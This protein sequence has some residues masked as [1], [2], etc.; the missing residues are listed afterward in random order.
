M[1]F[2]VFILLLRKLISNRKRLLA[3]QEKEKERK[4]QAKKVERIEKLLLELSK[5]KTQSGPLNQSKDL[6]DAL[7]TAVKKQQTDTRYKQALDFLNKK[8][9]EKAEQLFQEIAEETG[10]K[11]KE[12]S[13]E[14]AR[15]YRQLGA[16]AGLADPKRAVKAYIKSLE[17]E[18]D[19]LDALHW[20]AWIQ[21]DRGYTD[22]SQTYYKKIISL[23]PKENDIFYL[24][25][26]RLG[27]GDIQSVKGN[28]A[29]AQ[30]NYLTAQ[31][32]AKRLA[33]SPAF[34]GSDAA[35]RSIM[36]REAW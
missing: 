26:A 33:A 1:S 29:H 13:K 22:Q 9:F 25:W 5:G 32:I 2:Q 8:E 18:P 23:N 10:A 6:K 36:T 34:F 12:N 24:Y 4:E 15:S 27:L 11:A 7:T 3:E 20:A 30:S 21:K 19:N 35:R 28:L 16:I 17:F 31:K 14:A